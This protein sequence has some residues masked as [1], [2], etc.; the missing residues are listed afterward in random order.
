MSYNIMRPSSPVPLARRATVM[1]EAAKRYWNLFTRYGSDD[2]W[3]WFDCDLALREGADF[4]Q[5]VQVLAELK[6]DAYVL[7]LIERAIAAAQPSEAA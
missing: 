2:Q 5:R 1:D 7:D 4:L 3:K 6:G